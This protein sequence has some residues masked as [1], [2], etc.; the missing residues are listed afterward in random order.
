MRPRA[1]GWPAAISDEHLLLALGQRVARRLGRPGH[2][3]RGAPDVEQS[4]RRRD[5]CA[6]HARDS[7]L[8]SSAADA[9]ASRRPAPGASATVGSERHPSAPSSRARTRCRP[10][11]QVDAHETGAASTR[12]RPVST[13]SWDDSTAATSRPSPSTQVAAGLATAGSTRRARVWRYYASSEP[14]EARAAAQQPVAR[15]PSGDDPRRRLRPRGGAD[16]IALASARR[17]TGSASRAI[18]SSASPGR[19]AAPRLS[20]PGR[21]RWRSST[22]SSPGC[23]GDVSVLDASRA[24]AAAGRAPAR[25]HRHHDRGRRDG[26]LQVLP[27][28]VLEL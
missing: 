20:R 21:R 22:R 8:Y 15:G 24:T 10:S 27:A 23:S 19:A 26:A 18:G 2:R 7:R 4:A 17:S 9:P 13:P 12:S 5:G 28:A 3:E 14:A 25:A 1:S 6:E 11:G 16:G